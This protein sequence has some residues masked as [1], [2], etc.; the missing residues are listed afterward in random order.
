MDG[1]LTGVDN[2]VIMEHLEEDDEVATNRSRATK[3]VPK[4]SKKIN[5]HVSNAGM[6]NIKK[7][8]SVEANRLDNSMNM[9]KLVRLSS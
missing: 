2:H 4:G 6:R 8:Q 1:L 3:S 9:S 5:I 7:L